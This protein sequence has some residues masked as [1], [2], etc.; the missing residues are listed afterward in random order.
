MK[1][2]QSQPSYTIILPMIKRY[3]SKI[4]SK[5]GSNRYINGTSWR[6]SG[7]DI[8]KTLLKIRSESL[9]V[10]LKIGTSKFPAPVTDQNSKFAQNFRHV[11][12]WEFFHS[13]PWLLN[14]W[15][16]ANFKENFSN[17]SK[18]LVKEITI[19]IAYITFI[20]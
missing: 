7:K 11:I 9:M 3:R 20:I 18:P 17:F 4:L 5:R 6:F 8:Y 15:K 10:V 16:T 2:L 19:D 12:S 1:I 14:L 13:V